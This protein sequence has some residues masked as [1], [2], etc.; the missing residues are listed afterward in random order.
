LV[1]SIANQ[2]RTIV[3][4]H[5]RHSYIH[6]HVNCDRSPLSLL[7]ET[8][9]SIPEPAHDTRV[10]RRFPEFIEKTNFIELFR[11]SIIKR[12]KMA[13]FFTDINRFAQLIYMPQ[14]FSFLLLEQNQIV[15]NCNCKEKA[16]KIHAN[17]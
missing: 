8:A 11:S 6:K 4:N 12:R 5:C 7:N 13:R 3:I 16:R 1:I 10:S 2:V 9:L 15:L 17:H 14:C